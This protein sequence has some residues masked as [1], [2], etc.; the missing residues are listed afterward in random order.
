[1]TDKEIDTDYTRE[2]VCPFCGYEFGDSWEI[3]F[4]PCMEGDT[5]VTC[6]GCEKDFPVSRHIEITYSSW[7]KS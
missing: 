1:M 5:E 2:V 4:G 7:I 6:G 3:D